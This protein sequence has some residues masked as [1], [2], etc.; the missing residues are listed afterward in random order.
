MDK[1]TTDRRSA[2][3]IGHLIQGGFNF[4]STYGSKV[5]SLA[6]LKALH[7]LGHNAS[8][9][10]LQGNRRVIEFRDGWGGPE[11]KALG[12]SG[13]TSFKF[14]EG[15]ARFIQSKLSLPYSGLFDSFRFREA[16][17]KYLSQCD[18]FHERYTVMGLG[19]TWAARKLSIPLILE[20]HA[21]IINQE[22]P[23]HKNPLLGMQRYLAEL[24]TQRCF[25]QAAKIVVVSRAVGE[26]LQTYWRVP[27]EKIVIVPNAVDLELFTC[28]ARRPEVRAELG[29]T[30][31]PVVMFTGSFQPWHGLDRLI[32][33]FAK[34]TSEIPAAKLVLVGD[35]VTVSRAE[36]EGQA[37]QLG[38]E[39]NIVFTGGVS[40]SRIPALLSVADVAVAPYPDLS[41]EL[42]FSPLKLFEYM[43]AAK[44]IVASRVGQTAEVLKD[45]RTGLLVKP[46]D[47]E[48]LGKAIIK[49]LKEQ[50]LRLRLGQNAHEE[51]VKKHSWKFRAEK[52]EEIYRSVL[53][54]S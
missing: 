14:A 54:Q 24:T 42:W 28:D 1:P 23:L 38:L 25:R 43:A 8:L 53:P 15:I 17:L 39:N 19:G 40:Y 37:R 9:L 49:L 30:N 16:C 22:M 21:D 3:T 7:S 27:A 26:S 4:Q 41:A 35:G 44:A 18:V 48:A 12:L 11:P 32:E 5:N 46:G 47:T 20:V 29:L 34:V 51:A 31:E 10:A 6:L 13:S 2:L 33:A 50:Y 52:L 45:G 36:L